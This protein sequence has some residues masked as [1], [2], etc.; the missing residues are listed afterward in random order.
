MDRQSGLSCFLCREPFRPGLGK[1][2]GRR[3]EKWQIDVCNL[4]LKTSAGGLAPASNRKLIDHLQSLRIPVRLNERGWID[5]PD[6]ALEPA[7]RA[8][9]IRP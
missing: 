5:W 6:E 2:D 3:I 7:W 8:S 1:Y 9:A 4:C